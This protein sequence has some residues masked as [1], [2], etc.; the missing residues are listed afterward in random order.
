MNVGSGSAG[1]AIDASEATALRAALERMAEAHRRTSINCRRR[2]VFDARR[3][4]VLQ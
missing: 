1:I 2:A 4:C 3:G